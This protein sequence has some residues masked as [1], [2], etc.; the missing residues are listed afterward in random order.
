MKKNISLWTLGII[1]CLQG[2]AQVEKI[3]V[4]SKLE[5]SVPKGFTPFSMDKRKSRHPGVLP[6]PLWLISYENGKVFASCTYTNKKVD[7]NG[8]PAFTDELIG[9]LKASTKDFKLIDDGILLQEGK[10]IGYIK[11]RSQVEDQKIFNYMFY[12]SLEE[13]LVLFSFDCPKKLRKKWE[14][15]ARDVAASLKLLP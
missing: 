14:S 12:I 3:I 13:R 15:K 4:D 8:I 2:F 9:E 10:N 5:T 6:N 1:L 7:D 11:F